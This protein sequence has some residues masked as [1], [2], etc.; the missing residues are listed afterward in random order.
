VVVV[1][2]RV[3]DADLSALPHG[4]SRRRKW[5]IDLFGNRQGVHV[6]A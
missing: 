1:S 4:R 2:A 5:Q 6:G 3:H